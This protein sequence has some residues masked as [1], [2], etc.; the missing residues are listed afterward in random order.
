M[1]IKSVFL[2]LLV[3]VFVSCYPL[4]TFQG[5]DVLPE[6]EE[7]LGMGL[8]WMTNII[9]LEDSSTGN[10]TAFM[11]DASVLFRRGFSNNIDIGIKF[12]GR[13]WVDGALLTDVKWLVIH[14]PVKVALDFGMS[15]WTNIDIYS[16]VGYHP[17]IIVGGDN[18]FAQFQYNY[19][20]SRMN[21][22][23]TQDVILG[24]HFKMKNSNYT[25]TPLFGLHRD[26][27]DPENIFYSLGFGFR[28][29]L[30]EWSR[31]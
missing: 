21:V 22:L 8:S 4:G 17:S 29:P 24:R 25:F 2:P 15:Y 7:T 14:K 13:P 16:F 26:E 19:I 28:G 5:P 23:R 3:I 1:Y 11:A 12:V 9:A 18:L 31:P 20:R 27:D 30:D 10:E 6:G